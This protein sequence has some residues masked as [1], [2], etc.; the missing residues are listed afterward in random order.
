M[1]T[2]EENIKNKILSIHGDTYSLT[3]F[4][5]STYKEKVILTCKIHG[6][7]K[8][9]LSNLIGNKRGCPDCGKERLKKSLKSNTKEFILKSNKIHQNR[10]LYDRVEYYNWNTKVSIICKIHG[11]FIQSPNIHLNGGGCSKCNKGRPKKNNVPTKNQKVI[12]KQKIFIEASKEIH[13]NKYDYSFVRYIASNKKVKILCKKHGEFEQT[14]S[15]HKRGNGCGS[16]AY[17]NSFGPKITTADFISKSKNRHFG[18]YSYDKSEY[19]GN[20]NKVRITCPKHGDFFQIPKYH[21]NGGGCP[22]C[23]IGKQGKDIGN[24]KLKYT[25]DELIEMSIKLNGLKYDYRICGGVT[26]FERV[27][28]ND[29]IKNNYCKS[30]NINLLR[31]NYKDFKNIENIIKKEI[32]ENVKLQT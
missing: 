2:S 25:T 23:N 13:N 6:D 1:K 3:K 24:K 8:I 28:K 18:Y 9:H 32:I 17:E 11:E 12:E 30:N 10:Y 19:T 29:E 26:T 5:Y 31:I 16:C 7:F 4:K 20:K 14:P 15:H 27:K 22:K 21:M